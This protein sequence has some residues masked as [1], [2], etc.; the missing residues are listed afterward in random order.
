MFQSD[1]PCFQQ[2]TTLNSCSI[3]IFELSMQLIPAN[4]S[5][6]VSKKIFV[7]LAFKA[8]HHHKIQQNPF[9]AHKIGSFTKYNL[10][11]RYWKK[12]VTS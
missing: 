2:F 12:D 10:R 6:K 4:F 5:F 11:G 1:F 7:T 3:F 9:S 8:F